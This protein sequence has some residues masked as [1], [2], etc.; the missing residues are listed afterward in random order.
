MRPV[1][2]LFLPFL[3]FAA[4]TQTASAP[5]TRKAE[6]SVCAMTVADHIGTP[7]D[8]VSANWDHPTP[9]GG[10]VVSVRSA[11]SLHTCEIDADLA[12]RQLVHPREPR[13]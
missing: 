11:E 10:A 13:T 12:V 4:C 8:S 1:V 5:E 6:E 7:V 9:G 3:A 2:T